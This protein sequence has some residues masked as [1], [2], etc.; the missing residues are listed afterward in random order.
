VVKNIVKK[1]LRRFFFMLLKWLAIAVPATFVNSSI[2]YLENELALAFRT[3]LVRHAYG[4]YFQSETYYRISNLDTRIANADHCL[5]DD[6]SEFCQ[7]VAHLYS[8][9]TKPLLDISIISFSL[10]RMG[11]SLGGYL[12]PSKPVFGLWTRE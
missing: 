2:R 1:D 9:I 4:K 8:H 6:I 11:Q 5:T 12:I 10:I 3:R 7:S